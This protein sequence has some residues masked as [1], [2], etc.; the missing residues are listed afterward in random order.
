[1]DIA[2]TLHVSER[3]AKRLVAHLL[4]RLRVSSRVEAAA[5]A[6]RVGLVQQSDG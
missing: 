6:G 3:T 4:R 5:L 2:T 1:M